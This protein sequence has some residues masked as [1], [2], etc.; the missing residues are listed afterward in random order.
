MKRIFAKVLVRCSESSNNDGP[1]TDEYPGRK[2]A[3]SRNVARVSGTINGLSHLDDRIVL[4]CFSSPAV[5]IWLFQCD[6][7]LGTSWEMA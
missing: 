5:F 3:T 7:K 6:G 1:T 2:G 4:Y